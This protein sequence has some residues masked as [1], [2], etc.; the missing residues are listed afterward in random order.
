MWGVMSA[1]VCVGCGGVMSAEVW[2]GV[3]SA[4]HRMDAISHATHP[5][6][7]ISSGAEHSAPLYG[8]TGHP[9]RKWAVLRCNQ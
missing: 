5:T 4:V 3:M 1:E 9:D 2:W 7:Y 8:S 6:G